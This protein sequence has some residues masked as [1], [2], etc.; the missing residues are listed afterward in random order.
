MNAND[1]HENH[2]IL[3]SHK[4]DQLRRYVEIKNSDLPS[5]VAAKKTREFRCPPVEQV[6]E[7]NEAI[8]KVSILGE[9]HGSSV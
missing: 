4:Q 7:Y 5:A 2:C 1:D 9:Y 3:Y 8:I 6:L